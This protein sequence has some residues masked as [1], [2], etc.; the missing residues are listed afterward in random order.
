MVLACLTQ[1]QSAVVREVSF[2]HVTP[3]LGPA[4]SFE[5]AG[6]LRLFTSTD[7]SAVNSKLHFS[8]SKVHSKSIEKYHFTLKFILNFHL[9]LFKRH[10]EFSKAKYNFTYLFVYK[11]SQVITNKIYTF[12]IY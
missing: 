11:R 5:A 6:H 9:T 1:D 12:D 10:L 8:D 7:Q 4:G 3:S 2:V